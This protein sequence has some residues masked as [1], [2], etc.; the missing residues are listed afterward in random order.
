MRLSM[1]LCKGYATV[2]ALALAGFLSAPA[3]EAQYVTYDPYAA[4]S[5]GYGVESPGISGMS[6]TLG[7]AY[8]VRPAIDGQ[9]DDGAAE[10][11]AGYEND[12]L[13]D[14]GDGTDM[15]VWGLEAGVF[16]A[17]NE[18]PSPIIINLN[19]YATY[20]FPFSAAFEPPW[21]AVGLGGKV[22]LG[23]D[24]DIVPWLTATPVFS[25]RMIGAFTVSLDIYGGMALPMTAADAVA[26]I[27]GAR[28]SMVFLLGDL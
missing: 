14:L 6:M 2:L 26:V 18:G 1:D 12:T 25:I 23:M 16:G 3:A 27:A 7:G 13:T 5:S 21:F 15:L 22:G 28:L 17:V 24:M 10:F 9:P 4:S 19:G 8:M 20:Y 11:Y